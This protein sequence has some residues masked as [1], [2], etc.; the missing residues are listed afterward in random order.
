MRPVPARVDHDRRCGHASD[1][2]L[3]LGACGR[4]IF[5]KAAATNKSHPGHHTPFSPLSSDL[6][7]HHVTEYCDVGAGECEVSM[8]FLQIFNEKVPLCEC[9]VPLCSPA[10]NLACG[11]LP[12]LDQALP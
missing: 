6:L 10:R 7:G 1:S 2:A 12:R 11:E 4:D 8:S 5:E 9:A 3:W